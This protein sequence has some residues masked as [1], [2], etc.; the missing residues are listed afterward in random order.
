MWIFQG[1]VGGWLNIWYNIIS[2]IFLCIFNIPGVGTEWLNYVL[3][4][5]CFSVLPLLLLVK[6]RNTLQ[7]QLLIVFVNDC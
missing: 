4:F 3:P 2:V 5:S 7:L 6:V 1:I